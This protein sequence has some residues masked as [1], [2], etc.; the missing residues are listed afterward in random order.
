MKIDTR[1]EIAIGERLDSLGLNCDLE[2]FYGE[3]DIHFRDRI[4]FESNPNNII[5]K[6]PFL[7]PSC[8][9]VSGETRTGSCVL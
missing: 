5:P 1:L 8:K 6:R 7:T 4:R 2:R 3:T 9:A